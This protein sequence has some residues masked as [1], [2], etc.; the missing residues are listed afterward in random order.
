LPR[1]RIRLGQPCGNAQING[2]TEWTNHIFLETQSDG[3]PIFN[4][5]YNCTLPAVSWVIPDKKWS[6]HSGA[7]ETGPY[8]PSFV[9]DIIDAVGGGMSGSNCNGANSGHYWTTEP[10]AIFVVW[11]DW[12]GWFD[13][14]NP[15]QNQYPGVYVSPNSTSCPTN[16]QPNGWGCGY[17]YGFRV[18][19]LVVSPYTK[20]GYV[21]GAC[22]GTCPNNVFPFV[23]DFGSILAFTEYN[24]GMSKISRLFTRTSTPS[25]SGRITF[26]LGIS[27]ARAINVRSLTFRRKSRTHISRTTTCT[28]LPGCPTARMGATWIEARILRRARNEKNVTTARSGDMVADSGEKSPAVPSL[29]RQPRRDSKVLP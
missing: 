5:L 14:V 15:S 21:S 2:G 4:A 7:G 11:D 6:D 10:T 28:T 23:H 13:H 3:A 22:T 19:L 25:T 12:G 24:F 18:P 17:T 9:G 29:Q 20:A 8:G 1:I 16:I 27:S 26:R